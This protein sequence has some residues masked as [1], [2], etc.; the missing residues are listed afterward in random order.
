MIVAFDRLPE[1]FP[2]HRHDATFWEALGRVV[3]TFGFLEE[4]LGRAIFAYTG[5][6]KRPEDEIKSTYE[7]WV[8]T[9]QHALSDPLGNLIGA[10]CKAVLDHG[11]A[12][13]TDFDKLDTS[14]NGLVGGV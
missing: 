5:M 2:T 3:A 14:N 9:L 11:E 12:E 6:R 1:N 13:I 8:K 10:Y 4:I 7:E